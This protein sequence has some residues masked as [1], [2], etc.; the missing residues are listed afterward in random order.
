MDLKVPQLAGYPD[1]GKG[2]K[3]SLCKSLGLKSMSNSTTFLHPG[4][5]CTHRKIS[6]YSKWNEW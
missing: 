4:Q 5:F 3:I 2:I 6:S 1:S